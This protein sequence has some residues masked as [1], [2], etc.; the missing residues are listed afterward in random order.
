MT[1]TTTGARATGRRAEGVPFTTVRLERTDAAGAHA[2]AVTAT[3][4]APLGR[5]RQ[6]AVQRHA[7]RLDVSVLRAVVSRE[8]H[9]RDGRGDLR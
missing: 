2:F 9:Q 7:T 8:A 4:R 5:R 1:A 3:P 6:A